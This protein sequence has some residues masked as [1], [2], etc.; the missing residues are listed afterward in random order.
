MHVPGG[1]RIEIQNDKIA[2]SAMHDE[3]LFVTL[4]RRFVAEDASGPGPARVCRY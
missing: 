2:A 4:L 1:V 3:I